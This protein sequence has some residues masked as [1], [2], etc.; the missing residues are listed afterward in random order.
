MCI[1]QKSDMSVIFY[2]KNCVILKTVF[3]K[4]A[5]AIEVVLKILFGP[6]HRSLNEFLTVRSEQIITLRIQKQVR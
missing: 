3:E 1:K 4:A 2:T 5:L 6:Q